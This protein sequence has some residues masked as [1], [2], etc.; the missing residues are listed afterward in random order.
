MDLVPDA[1][2]RLRLVF[3]RG[4]VVQARL[5][6]YPSEKAVPQRVAID[7]E[8]LVH[9]DA[10]PSGIGADS[11]DRVVDYSAVVEAARAAAA[12]G[13]VL[14]AETLAERIADRVLREQRI[15]V[16]RVTV[17]KPEAFAD[18]DR[19]GVT[20]ERRPVRAGPT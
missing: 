4:L 5:G 2:R 1:E 18:V 6:V 14:L 7:V 15:E 3:I 13:H 8:L 16:V 17:A 9:D 12:E 11:L 10:A 19:V 20:I